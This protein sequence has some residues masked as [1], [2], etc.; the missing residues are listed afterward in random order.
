MQLLASALFAFAAST[1]ATFVTADDVLLKPYAS[2]LASPLD[3]RQEDGS[4]SNNDTT[5]GDV[6]DNLLNPDGTI[7]MTSFSALTST[8]CTSKLSSLRRTTSPSGMSICFNL[9]S[10]NTTNGVFEA[11]LRLY[12]VTEPRGAWEG[13]KPGD[14]DVNVGFANARVRNV[15]EKEI[16]GIGMV[17]EL[18][19]R[20][21]DD[22]VQEL[23]RYMLVG[24]V[25]QDKLD[26]NMTMSA[27]EA[28]LMPSLS[29][30]APS[31]Q[32]SDNLT[33]LLSPNE[34]SFITG[35][36]STLTPQSSFSIAQAAVSS[37]LALL[38]EGE[39]AFILPGTQILIFP[40]GLIITGT[41]ALLGV[42]VYAF[43]TVER[44]RFREGYRD[45]VK[46]GVGA[47][48]I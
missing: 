23:Q 43:G 40:I 15:T 25:Q 4:S 44:W 41:W 16:M 10:L 32:S 14:V 35:V 46:G 20:Q 47:A 42:G 9:P 1:V 36:F 12:K 6:P 37:S 8:T 29:L 27:L 5:G 22:G 17:G 48:G 38:D 24:Q 13:V 3:A 28:L 11:D 7:N 45:R 2:L 18:Q 26:T 39:I 31:A 21:V 34:A 19:A 33:T 30:T